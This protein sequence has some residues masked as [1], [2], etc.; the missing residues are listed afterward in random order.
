[1]FSLSEFVRNPS[2]ELLDSCYKE[3]LLA[4]AAHFKIKMSRQLLKEE[5][6]GRWVTEDGRNCIEST[7]S[8][9]KGQSLSGIQII[10]NIH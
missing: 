6:G 5:I 7:C 4:I 9:C 3:D 2:L 8:Y 10:T 1:M